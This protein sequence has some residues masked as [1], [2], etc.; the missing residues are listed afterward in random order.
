MKQIMR[1]I[2]A[3]DAAVSKQSGQGENE[4]I[5]QLNS[6]INA[7]EAVPFPA[8]ESLMVQLYHAPGPQE[9]HS[10]NRLMKQG[11]SMPTRVNPVL[12]VIFGQQM[13][14]ARNF[15]SASSE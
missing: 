10:I 1:T 7:S 5:R 3:M 14:L 6:A 13:S 11:V 15:M 4:Q 12:F 8:D 9:G 2:R